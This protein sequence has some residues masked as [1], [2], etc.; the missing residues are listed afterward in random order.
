MRS[1]YRQISKDFWRQ[2]SVSILLIAAFITALIPIPNH[3]YEPSVRKD[4]SRP[5]P[6]QDRPC[7]CRSAEQC[8]KKCCCFSSEQKQAWARR[9]G[10]ALAEV[11]PDA[12]K[13]DA[14]SQIAPRSCCTQRRGSTNSSKA[15]TSVARGM[16]KSQQRYRYMVGIAA[17]KCQGVDQTFN[18]QM[19]F[20][21]PEP[22]S[23]SETAE[24]NGERL[25]PPICRF[26]PPKS[27]PP[28]PPPRCP[29]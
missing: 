1:F 17:Q 12:K 13:S 22:I 23:C 2:R 6:C 3:S 21:I 15:S 20:L 11:I 27:D 8:R 10:V 25:V 7:G 29:V 26:E 24:P 14:S 28:V 19:V 5:F 18:G 16:K 9:N 4:R